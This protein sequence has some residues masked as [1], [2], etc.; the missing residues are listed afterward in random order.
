MR[1][2]KACVLA[3]VVC[4]AL[5]WSGCATIVSGGRQSVSFTSDPP[6]ATV[7]AGGIMS[8]TPGALNLKTNKSYIVQFSK[9]GYQPASV[10]I[11]KEFNYWVLCNIFWEPITFTLV[12][13][14]TGAFW[15]L[16]QDSVHA[17]LIKRE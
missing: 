8:S 11:G 12:D 9:E 13:L 16:D 2:A 14:L 4:L 3:V 10:V 6:G 7:N 15:K 5:L 17:V 1:V